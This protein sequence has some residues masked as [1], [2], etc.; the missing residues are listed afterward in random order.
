MPRD[1]KV[2][3]AGAHRASSFLRTF[4]AHPE[5]QMVALCDVNERALAETGAAVGITQLYTSYE[6]MLDEARPDAVVVAT[7]MQHH[8][9]QSI[10]ALQRGIHVLSEVTA[11]V[12]IDEARWLV[13]ECKRSRAIYMMAENYTYMRPNVLVRSM[14]E[15]GLF[16]EVYYAEGEY[17][18]EVSA[19]H[20]T[21]EGRP[22]WRYYWQVGINGCTYPTHSLGPCLQWIKERPERISCIGTGRWTDPEHAIEDTIL[23]LCKTASGKLVRVRLDM[24]SKRPHAMTNYTLQGTRGAYESARRPGE[25]N[26]VWVEGYCQD[27]NKWL[28][29]EAFEAEFLPEFW[30]HPP[31]EALEAGHGGGDYFEVM[32]FVDAIRGRK[33]APIGIHEAMDM[34]LPGL[35]SQESIR[36]GGEWLPVPDSR[37]W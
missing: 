36:R 14:V 19:L 3:F 37:E 24:L 16:G 35:V 18:H 33:P 31:P 6:K 9:P 11:A 2:A 22:T 29:L 26:W 21:P 1:I 32:D 8:V 30:R 13:Q 23:L 15:A 5:T 4:Q 27:P 10:A 28:P 34:T 25:G 17:I 20:H 12:S 7:P